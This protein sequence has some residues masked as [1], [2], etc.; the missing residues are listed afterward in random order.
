MKLVQDIPRLCS[1]HRG[2]L[3]APEE[4]REGIRDRDKV[5]EGDRNRGEKK[6]ARKS[7]R[8][9][10]VMEGQRTASGLRG[11]RLSVEKWQFVKIKGTIL[12]QSEVFNFNWA[13]YLGDFLGFR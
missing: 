10:F 8:G 2:V 5:G 11:N 3:F 9:L 1:Q 12:C 4:Q 6:G 13:C 7:G